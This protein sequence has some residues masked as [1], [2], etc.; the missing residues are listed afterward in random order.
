MHTSNRLMGW[1]V[2]KQAPCINKRILRIYMYTNLT[3][4]KTHTQT[5]PRPFVYTEITVGTVLQYYRSHTRTL[6]LYIIIYITRSVFYIYI[7]FIYIY[8]IN[9]NVLLLYRKP[10]LEIFFVGFLLYNMPPSCILTVK[11]FFFSKPCAIKT[12]DFIV[13]THFHCQRISV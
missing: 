5:A 11:W 3:C 13:Y 8:V 10:V 9:Y 2:R 1:C 12:V 4:F 6:L 7:L